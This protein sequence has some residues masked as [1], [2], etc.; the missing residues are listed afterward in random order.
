WYEAALTQVRSMERAV[1]GAFKGVANEA[2][3][4]LAGTG[5]EAFTGGKTAITVTHKHE[6]TVSGEVDVNGEQLKATVEQRVARTAYEQ[7]VSGVV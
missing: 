2:N 4:A 5:L 3:V 7:G 1:G 6:H